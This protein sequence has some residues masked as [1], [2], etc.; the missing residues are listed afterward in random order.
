LDRSFYSRPAVTVAR[1][2]LGQRLVRLD[3]GQ[4]L[5]GTICEV[6][7]YSGESDLGCHCKHGRTPRT[8]VM[9][10]PAGFTYVYFTYGM[11]WCLNFVVEEEG[12]PAVVLI[13][14]LIPTEGLG[15]IESR[16]GQQPPARWTD[17]PG[18]ICQALAITGSLN[19][20]DLCSPQSVVWVE[21]AEAIPDH[22]V[23]CGPRVGLNNVPEP[24][25]SVPWRFRFLEAPFPFSRKRRIRPRRDHSLI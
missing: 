23:I 4:R 1:E 3:E 7:A 25:K 10:G 24:W 21:R 15:I 2:L 5:A 8:Q 20:T 12:F 9:Y 14:A 22:Q 11:H 16:R 19:A 13:R 17:G 6:E 18:I